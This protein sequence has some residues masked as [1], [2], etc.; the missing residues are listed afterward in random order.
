MNAEIVKDLIR[1]SSLRLVLV[2]GVGFSV[3]FDC[4]QKIFATCT[5]LGYFVK[6]FQLK[7]TSQLR[8]RITHVRAASVLIISKKALRNKCESNY[9]LSY[10]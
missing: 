10:C 1:V 7:I 9:G 8:D 3:Y 4:Q 2:T 6:W 5:S